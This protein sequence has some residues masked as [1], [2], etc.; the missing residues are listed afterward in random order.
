MKNLV[1][2]GG[3]ALAAS[4][5]FAQAGSAAPAA[6]CQELVAF[7]KAPPV[8]A[9]PAKA[10]EAAK[11]DDKTDAKAGEAAKPDDKAAA[12]PDDKAEAPA[13]PAKTEAEANAAVEKD[14]EQG[15]SAQDASGQ[16]GPAHQAPE[17]G[18]ESA[19]SKA[20][21]AEQNAPLKSGLSAPVPKEPTSTPKESVM[22]VAEAEALAGANDIA[23][24]RDAG[25]KLRVAGVAV[26]SPLLALIALDLQYQ[27]R[28]APQPE[29]PQTE[30]APE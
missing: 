16:S 18:S 14:G 2:A 28:E 5:V 12:K 25:R 6:L 4:T 30:T 9:A 10:G 29:A 19:S 11:A 21:P 24:C 8:E 3:F 17:E 15:D 27:T 7:M 22:T 23:A 26:P 1:L 20:E 13:A